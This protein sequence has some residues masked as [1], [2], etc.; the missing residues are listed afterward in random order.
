MISVYFSAT[1]SWGI[2]VREPNVTAS[3]PSLQ[4]PPP[5]TLLGA[6]AYG[7][8]KALGIGYETKASAKGR[9][10]EITNLPE[11]IYPSLLYAGASLGP[12]TLHADINRYI[13]RTFQK[14]SRERREDPNYQFGALP[15]GKTYVSG[16]IR[17]VLAFDERKLTEA[18][19]GYAGVK[20]KDLV[21]LLRAS[22]SYIT[23]LGS[24]EGI[25]AVNEVD[26]GEPKPL[27]SP[28]FESSL[29]QYADRVKIKDVPEC[30]LALGKYL[31]VRAWKGG[32]VAQGEPIYLLVPVCAGEFFQSGKGAFT[33]KE[34]CKAYEFAGEGFAVC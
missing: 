9:K 10:A 1:P 31:T 4:V 16:E 28:D 18:I 22:A 26:V 27:S 5:T 3:Q 29:Y 12:Y 17:A 13:I 23:R 19:E 7:I 15:V 14:E 34:G 25:I 2:I 21:D 6:L 33:A 32:F 20:V 30:Q 24:K 11:A 8:A